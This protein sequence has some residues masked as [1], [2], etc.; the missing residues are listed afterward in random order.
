MRFEGICEGR[1]REAAKIGPALGFE[2]SE[3]A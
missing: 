3:E 2:I 1:S